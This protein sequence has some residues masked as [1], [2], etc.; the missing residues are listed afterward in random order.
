MEFVMRGMSLACPRSQVGSKFFYLSKL[1]GKQ[2][3]LRA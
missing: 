2:S 1:L 3:V